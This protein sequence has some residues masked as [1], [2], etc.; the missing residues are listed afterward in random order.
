MKK[1]FEDYMQTVNEGQISDF[2]LS[3]LRTLLKNLIPDYKQAENLILKL[4]TL[5]TKLN[6]DNAE[7]TLSDVEEI[8]KKILDRISKESNLIAEKKS[9]LTKKISDFSNNLE[10]KIKHLT[11]SS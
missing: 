1:K 9:E 11:S 8:K 5:T 10:K 7:K 3:P 4:E 6:K 2:L